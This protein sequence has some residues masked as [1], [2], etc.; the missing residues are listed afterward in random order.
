MGRPTLATVYGSCSFFFKT[1]EK[2]NVQLSDCYKYI[3]MMILIKI[4]FENEANFSL[5]SIVF[6]IFYDSGLY[7]FPD[8][9][10]LTLIEPFV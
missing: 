2:L 6:E 1:K 3:Q 10:I 8:S 7:P 4:N 9:L 5:A